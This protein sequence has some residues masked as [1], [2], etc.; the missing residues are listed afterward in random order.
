MTMLNIL[1]NMENEW[2]KN[3]TQWKSSVTLLQ[4]NNY[5]EKPFIRQSS[6]LSF[7]ELTFCT[8]LKNEFNGI[9]RFPFTF[10]AAS[11]VL[12]FLVCQQT[13]KLIF[14]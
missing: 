14:L 11:Q 7:K 12:S 9:K 4:H 1:L 8:K 5:N 10:F 2:E 6:R 13:K 3:W